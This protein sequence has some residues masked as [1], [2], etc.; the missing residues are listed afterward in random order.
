MYFLGIDGGGTKTK[1]YVIDENKNVIHIG[2][3]GPS[4]LDTVT[5]DKT[6]KHIN[7]G[8][9][10][11]F[12]KFPEATFKVVF[13]G[14]GG[15][16]N[17]EYEEKLTELLKGVKGVA[18]DTIRVGKSDMENAL[19]SGLCFDEGISLIAGTG[20][21]CFGKNKAGVTKRTG[22]LGF[23]EGDMGSGY[24]LGKM[25]LSVLAKAS[26]GRIEETNFTKELKYYF[27][28]KE[29]SDVAEVCENLFLERTKVASLAPIVTTNAN[30]GDKYA[31][32]I[33]EIATSELSLCVEAVY[34]ELNVS[35][36]DLVVVGTLGNV[37]GNFKKSLHE[38][39]KKISKNINIIEPKVDPAHA[40]S[41]MAYEIYKK[42]V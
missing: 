17:K 26:D 2:N 20:M 42:R 21:V 24:S 30:K 41:L 40:A 8:L 13:A 5:N 38:K 27:D 4:S 1:C 9:V 39:I 37:D 25:A 23:K 7:D 10:P 36:I 32:E 34:K 14:L 15:V 18:K 31:N 28:I 6:V 19:Y 33:I 3:G 16:P 22:G 29:P 35:N 11:F 12:K